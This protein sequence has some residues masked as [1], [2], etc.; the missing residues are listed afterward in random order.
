[1]E[2]VSSFVSLL[3]PVMLLARL[4]ANKSGYN[5]MNEFRIPIFLNKILEAIMTVELFLLK[6]GVRFPVG[7]S[8]LLLAKKI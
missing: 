8:L 6:N 3:L 2:Y 4:R 1:M 5:P 7:G